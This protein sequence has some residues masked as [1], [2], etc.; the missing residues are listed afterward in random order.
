[1]SESS[2]PMP[3][4]TFD[5]NFDLYALR[6]LSYLIGVG[7][8]A[9]R[10]VFEGEEFTVTFSVVRPAGFLSISL[11]GRN[12]AGPKVLTILVDP[13]TGRKMVTM[14]N[15]TIDAEFLNSFIYGFQMAAGI[16]EV[17]DKF[18]SGREI[19]RLLGLSEDKVEIDFEGSRYSVQVSTGGQNVVFSI[20]EVGGEGQ[21]IIRH[22]RIE[23]GNFIDGY[24]PKD[25]ATFRRFVEELIE[26]VSPLGRVGEVTALES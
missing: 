19:Y 21:R 12:E 5:D 17:E 6:R 2:A 14:D 9:F 24:S 8:G 15:G 16:E 26:A 4:S 13:A 18:F 25:E 10:A 7:E 22:Y 11:S 23:K 20:E 1:M 3:V